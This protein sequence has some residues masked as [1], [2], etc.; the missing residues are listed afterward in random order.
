MG[1]IYL[2][3]RWCFIA[4]ESHRKEYELHGLCILINYHCYAKSDKCI[5]WIQC[6]HFLSSAIGNAF[7][8]LWDKSQSDEM[9][10]HY[11]KLLQETQWEE[12]YPQNGLRIICAW[13]VLEG[14]ARSNWFCVSRLPTTCIPWNL[15]TWKFWLWLFFC[16]IG[17]LPFFV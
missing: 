2:K 10:G 1:C 7:Q 3:D 14:R 5:T 8:L 9:H 17:S 4:H 15:G 13:L 6:R 16:L 12:S 11:E